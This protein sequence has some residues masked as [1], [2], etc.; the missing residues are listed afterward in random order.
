MRAAFSLLALLC[1]TVPASAQM[2]S[3]PASPTDSAV[4]NPTTSPSVNAAR[5]S[6]RWAE[7]EA[8]RRIA[9]GDYEGAVQ[10]QAQADADKRAAA[11]LETFARTTDGRR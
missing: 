5:K 4:L 10:A 9:D 2:A 6:A 11:R 8:D 1:L 7:V 3:Q